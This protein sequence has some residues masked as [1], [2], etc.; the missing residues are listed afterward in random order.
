MIKFILRNINICLKFYIKKRLKFEEF[1]TEK[2]NFII[3]I[4]NFNLIYIT[5]P[6]LHVFIKT[7]I[8]KK[9]GET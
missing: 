4:D 8:L 2:K 1:Y 3:R 5:L 9:K 6:C 7:L